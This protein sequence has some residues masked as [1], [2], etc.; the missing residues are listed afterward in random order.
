M[1]NISVHGYRV[2]QL[3]DNI[4]PRVAVMF[5]ADGLGILAQFS[6]HLTPEQARELSSQLMAAAVHAG[7]A[8]PGTEE[9]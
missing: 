6:M 5:S 4:G 1:K 9:V 8:D 2:E 3:G 7:H